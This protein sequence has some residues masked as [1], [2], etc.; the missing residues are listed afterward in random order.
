MFPLHTV[1]FL[2]ESH[3]RH[4]PFHRT[5]RARVL[6]DGGSEGSAAAY[7]RAFWHPLDADL[8]TVLRAILLLTFSYH[9]AAGI[10][11][12]V[13]DTGRGLER[14]QSKRSAW[15]VGIGQRAAR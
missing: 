7:E 3:H 13:W 1:H 8:Q 11:H 14:E 4:R 10:R 6:A 15:I 5:A 9:L 12:L 2:R